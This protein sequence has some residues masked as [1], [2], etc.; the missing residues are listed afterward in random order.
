MTFF[1]FMLGALATYRLALMFSKES[2]PGRIFQRLRKAPPPRSSAREGLSCP[3]CLSIWFA[4]AITGYYI[5][6]GLVTLPMS[7]V[8]ILAL[9]AVA[10]CLNQ[11]FTKG[12]L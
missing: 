5:W 10:V 6:L 3:F 8:Y 1:Y 11:V 4:V 2:G 12:E 7:P 9:S